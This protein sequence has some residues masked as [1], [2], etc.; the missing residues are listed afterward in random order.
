MKIEV[1]LSTMHYDQE[2]ANF[3]DDMN[4]Q[5]DIIIGNQCEYNE[6]RSFLFEGHNVTILSRKERGV[7]KNRNT[8]LFY[9]DADV[10]I[11][12]DN[13]VKYYD[14]YDLKVEEY[15]KAHPDADVVVFNFKEQRGDEPLHDI[16]SQNKK[17][18]LRSITKFGTWAVTA[19]R[20]SILKKRISFSLLFGGGAKYS[21]GEDSLFLSDCYKKGL[22]IYLSNITLGE[23]IH[24]DSTW[25]KGITE[26]YIF[27]KGALFRAMCPKLYKFVILRHVFKHK[28]MYSEFGKMR[29]VLKI[30]F[31]GAKAY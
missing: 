31:K 2:P 9:S 27:D 20:D 1:L 28:K 15:Y 13:D 24:R 29:D 3:L 14:G 6:N 11:F 23:V 16:N 26:K 8:S 4:V 5:T 12:A 25:Y 22:N 18:N 30:M 21:C 19:K 17:A 10:V 7:G